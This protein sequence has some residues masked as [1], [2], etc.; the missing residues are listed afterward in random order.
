MQ[1]IIWTNHA[2]KRVSDRKISQN[3][4]TDTINFPDSKI[5]NQDG[6]LELAR[7]YGK[8]KVNVVIKEN[9]KGE[10]I[11]LSCWIN[12]PNYNSADYTKK[13]YYKKVNKSSIVK[14]FWYTFLNQIGI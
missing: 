14:K 2:K 11:I 5:N 13:Q 4:I 6:S 12:P 10:L 7:E 8:Q 1:K 9:E 3:Q